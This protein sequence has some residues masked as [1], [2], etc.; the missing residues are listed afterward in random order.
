MGGMVAQELA[1]TA[2]ERVETLTL[3]CTYCGGEGSRFTDDAIVQDIAQAI[4]SGDAERKIRTGWTYNVSREYAA[5][6]GNLERFTEVAELYPVPLPVV[7]AQVQAILAHDTSA[8]LAQIVA[9]TLVVHGT[10]DQLLPVSN[11]ELVAGL[12]PDARLE[13]LEGVGHLFF[14]EQPERAAQLIAEHVAAARA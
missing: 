8:R 3:G 11:G 14:W 5:A 10:E 1:L 4:L 9:P 12:I 6:E 13:L 7:I 2:P